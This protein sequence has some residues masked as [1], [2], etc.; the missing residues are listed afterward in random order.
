MTSTEGIDLA[1]LI[2]DDDWEDEDEFLETSDGGLTTAVGD[3]PWTDPEFVEAEAARDRAA[4]IEE[5][6][7]SEESDTEPGYLDPEPAQ[8]ERK[9]GEPRRPQMSGHCMFPQSASPHLSHERCGRNGAGNR[10]VPKNKDGIKEFAPCPCDC[11]L[12]DEYECG[13]CGQPIRETHLWTG[14]GEVTYVHVDHQ[15]IATGENC[16]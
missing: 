15:G 2:E 5:T 8:P 16:A 1:A 11:H 7:V 9:R 13:N 10:A 14:D 6:E 12:G 3:Q 4:L